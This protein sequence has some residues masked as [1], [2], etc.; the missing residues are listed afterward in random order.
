MEI[1]SPR[2]E[3]GSIQIS[4]RPA[5]RHPWGV[6]VRTASS[7]V[8]GLVPEGWL[9]DLLVLALAAFMIGGTALYGLAVVST[10]T[11]SLHQPTV[12]RLMCVREAGPGAFDVCDDR[13]CC[14]ETR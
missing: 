9:I 13:V 10:W 11:P 12:G 8:R 2:I 3:K 14:K 4:F 7:A 1:T 6:V 5:I